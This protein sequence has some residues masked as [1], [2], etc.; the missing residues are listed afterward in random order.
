MIS[1]RRIAYLVSQYPAVN[2]TYILREIRELRRLGW[3]IQV[4]SI[5]ADARPSSQLTAEEREELPK[6]WYVIK[7]VSYTHLTLPTIA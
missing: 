2:H 5:R 4:A 1:S 7:P 6:T 3:D